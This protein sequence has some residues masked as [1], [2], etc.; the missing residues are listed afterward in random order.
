MCVIFFIV[1]NS[2]AQLFPPVKSHFYIGLDVHIFTISSGTSYKS[3]FSV[4][5]GYHY[6][7]TDNLFVGPQVEASLVKSPVKKGAVPTF[8]VG[9]SFMTETSNLFSK[10]Y[11]NKNNLRVS[12][13]LSWIFPINPAINNFDYMDKIILANSLKSPN[14]NEYRTSLDVNIHFQRY[15]VGMLNKNDRNISLSLGANNEFK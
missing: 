15:T 14:F 2:H 11:L 12:N 13:R 10:D 8:F 1:S 9:G 6:M 7:F 4:R 5:G 3:I